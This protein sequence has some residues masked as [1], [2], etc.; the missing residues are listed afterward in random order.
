MAGSTVAGA[1]LYQQIVSDLREEI[2]RGELG[3][4]DQIP[5]EADLMER[6]HVS[7]KY[8]SQS[9]KRARSTRS[10]TTTTP[11]YSSVRERHPLSITATRYERERGVSA[12]DAYKDELDAQSRTHRTKF[13]LANH[14]GA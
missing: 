5:T 4:G 14:P 6:Y 9:Y 7:L 10:P 2:R 8:C 1:P 13:A 3:P 11:G 12:N